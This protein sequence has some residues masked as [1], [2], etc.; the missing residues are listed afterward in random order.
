MSLFFQFSELM[1]VLNRMLGNIKK[2]RLNK[3]ISEVPDE[4]ALEL[5]R[6]LYFCS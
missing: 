5:R 3:M 1:V 6:F 2:E 4:E